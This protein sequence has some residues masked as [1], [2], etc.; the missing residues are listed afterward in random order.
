MKALVCM[1]PGSL[2]YSQVSNPVVSK[3]NA[4]IKIRR[5][6]ICGTD[7]HAFE[8]TQPFFEYPRILGHELAGELV[9]CDDNDT[10]SPGEN[11]TFIPYFSCGHCIACR[12]HKPNCCANIQVCGVHQHG[13]MVEYLSVPSYALVEGKGLSLDELALVEP[14]AIGAH[15]IQRA[16]VAAGEYVLIVGAGPIGLG[17]MEFARIKGAKVIALDISEERL[18]FCKTTLKVEHIINA[19]DDDVSDKLAG[20]TGGDMPAVVIDATGNLKAINKAFLYMAHGGR[21]VLIGLQRG[22]ISFSHPEFHKREATL[23]SSRNATRQDFEQVISCIKNKEL[24]PATYITHRVPFE[25]VKPAFKH[26]LQAS[27]GVIKAMVEME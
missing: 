8:G 3:G 11:V 10:F 20:I 24:N 21:Y 6:G 1:A 25:Q 18:A 13:G 22:D 15:G 5:I 27:N 2:E 14:L 19:N 12:L 9:T 26:W 7:L 16:G 4:I 17:T 23:L